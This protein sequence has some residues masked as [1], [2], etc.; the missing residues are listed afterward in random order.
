MFAQGVTRNAPHPVAKPGRSVHDD[1]A[2]TTCAVSLPE[3]GDIYP[4][5]EIDIRDVN[6]DSQSSYRCARAEKG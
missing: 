6:E 2:K 3:T 5:A 1:F 4:S